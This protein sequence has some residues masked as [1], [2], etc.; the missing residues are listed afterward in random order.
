MLI[1][2]YLH[3]T[4]YNGESYNL[5]WDYIAETIETISGFMIDVYRSESPATTIEEYECIASG[6]NANNY[7]YTDSS[8]SQLKDYGRP[9]FYKLNIIDP[10]RHEEE[11]QPETPAYFRDE[12]PDRVFREIVRNKRIALNNTRFS[13][14]DFRVFKRRTWGTHCSNCWDESLQR[15]TISNCT[16]CY[17]TGWIN[18]YYNP[19]TFRGMKNTSPKLSQINMFGE[20]KP[21][22]ALLYSLGYP[23][24]KPRDIIAD[25][26]DNLWTIV[27]IRTV[28]RRGY[29]IEQITQ[30]ALLAQDELLY[31]QLLSR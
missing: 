28:E 13:G 7:S 2:D 9:W 18:G 5:T 26:E 21:S 11:F 24:L 27:Q 23:P 22:D 31:K 10:I 19:V 25:D 20:W 14:R 12:V 30:L 29:V 16:T 3:V 4:T 8:I 17:G 1:L 15:T 6:I